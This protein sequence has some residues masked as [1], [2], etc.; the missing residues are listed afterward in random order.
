MLSGANFYY[1][2][3]SGGYSRLQAYRVSQDSVKDGR[4]DGVWGEL[5]QGSQT[6]RVEKAC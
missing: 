1:V 4:F 6:I 5:H 2:A 3:T